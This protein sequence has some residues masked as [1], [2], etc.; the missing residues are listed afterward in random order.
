M[1]RFDGYYCSPSIPYEELHGGAHL[2][3]SIVQHW[4]FFDDGTWL[5]V[6]MEGP[7][8]PFWAFSHSLVGKPMAEAKEIGVGISK[9]GK[10]FYFAGSYSIK[11][12]NVTCIQR[13]NA[14]VEPGATFEFVWRMGSQRLF[15]ITSNSHELMFVNVK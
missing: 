10:T 12:S 5:R 8:F 14:S 9:D 7:E 3:G 1:L 6:D 15:P 13:T 4:R 11:G 2:V